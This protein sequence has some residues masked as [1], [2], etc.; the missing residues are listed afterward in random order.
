MPKRSVFHAALPWLGA[1]S[2]AL[3]YAGWVRPWMLRWGATRAEAHGPLPGDALVPAPRVRFTRAI[4]LAAAPAQVWPWLV[5]IGCHRAGWYSYDA[6]DNAG[7]PSADHILP[8]LQNLA[9]GDEI[10]AAP[11]G[12]LAF[13]VNTLEPA[14]ALVLS[15]PLD[16]GLA[17]Y[18]E[19]PAEVAALAGDPVRASWAFV[20]R[21]L[22]CPAGAPART[23]LL[24]R[25]RADFAPSA[26]SSLAGALLEPVSFLMER[27]TLLG[28]KARVEA[29]PAPTRTIMG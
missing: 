8:E 15:G 29:A 28:I 23:R 27:K 12:T 17:F 25:F 10:W 26:L 21:P 18:P 3:A 19:A 13:A 6:L 16:Q 5:Q 22:P 14:H 9:V 1:A 20:L 24:I 4:T 11:D 2:A 7:L